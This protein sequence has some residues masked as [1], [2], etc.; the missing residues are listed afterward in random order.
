MIERK[1]VKQ[2]MKEFEI[3]EYVATSLSRVG[4]S[5]VKL[6]RT[7]LG[8]KIIISASRPGLVVGRAG[9]NITKLTRD[10]KEKFNLENPQIEIDEVTAI[11]SDP[12]IIAEMIANALE[13]FGSQ[14]F[15]GI[16]HRAMSD[17]MDSG[18]MGVEILIS[19]KI[20][21]SRATS[22]RFY[23]GY[24]KKCGDIALTGVNTA[25]RTA[26][27]K[28]GVVGVKVSIM[29]EGTILP[30]LVQLNEE[31]EEKVEELPEDQANKTEAEIIKKVEEDQEKATGEIKK[32]VKKE[33]K[34][35]KKAAKKTEK[36]PAKKKAAKS[37]KK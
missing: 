22:W 20:P 37:D 34:P 32:T 2:N 28:T 7:P 1:F 25:Y 27:L 13:R 33:D 8:E 11:G 12:N 23:Q 5:D 9:S 14:R 16:G 31:L 19:G 36:K 26:K 4:L 17:V 18:A 10:L 24:L 29:P 15:K 21:G 35:N 30:D 6:Q 3:K